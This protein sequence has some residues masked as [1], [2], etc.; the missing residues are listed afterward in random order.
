[1]ISLIGFEGNSL[2]WS[3][4]LLL[5]GLNLL[6]ED[7][8]SRLGGVDARCLD[9]YHEVSSV[10]D[11]EGCV[12]PKNTCLI[13]LGDISEDDVDHWHEHSVL[14]WMSG[15]LDDWDDI[16]SLLGHVDQVSSRSL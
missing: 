4:L 1:M 8:L 15:I 9:S 12:E 3:E 13:W 16:S 11:E 10:L 6:G 14:L 7:S 2:Y 5:E